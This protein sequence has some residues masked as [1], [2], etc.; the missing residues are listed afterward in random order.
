MCCR[1]AWSLWLS[2]AGR[3][4]KAAQ[5]GK[6]NHFEFGKTDPELT[7]TMSYRYKCVTASE[8][9]L[10]SILNDCKKLQ[11]F[12]KQ[13]QSIMHASVAERMNHQ[14]RSFSFEISIVRC[15]ELQFG[16]HPRVSATLRCKIQG[17]LQISCASIVHIVRNC[18]FREYI[19]KC[20]KVSY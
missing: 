17:V 2:D 20:S 4:M 12:R 7:H 9:Y 13:F 6:H 19:R 8:P 11:L 18:L 5:A 3:S 1:C 14:N 16:I 10:Y 15:E